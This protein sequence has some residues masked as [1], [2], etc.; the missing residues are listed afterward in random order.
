MKKMIALLLSMS[1]FSLMA[2]PVL[3]KTMP[4]LQD[5]RKR[6]VIVQAIVSDI[7]LNDLEKAAKNAN[8]LV[9]MVS[10]DSERMPPESLRDANTTLEKTIRLFLKAVEKKDHLAIIGGYSDIVGNCY[11]CHAKYRD[12][13]R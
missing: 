3:S 10:K 13:V 2:G 9:D 1:C 6:L 8:V 12:Q 4:Q 7:A 11:G 5:H